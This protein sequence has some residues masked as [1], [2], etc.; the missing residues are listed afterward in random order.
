LQGK[1][2]HGIAGYGW[3]FI[4]EKPPNGE[5]NDERTENCNYDTNNNA[6]QELPHRQ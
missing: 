5:Q 4:R 1:N 6:N 3:L 2:K